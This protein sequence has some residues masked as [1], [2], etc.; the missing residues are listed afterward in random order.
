MFEKYHEDIEDR[1]TSVANAV[2]DICQK[3][4]KYGFTVGYHL[5]DHHIPKANNGAWDIKGNEFDD[6]DNRW[7]AYYSEDY[8]N[9]YKKKSGKYLYV[10]RAEISP[11]SSHKRD[12]SNKWGR[13][14][15]LSIIDECDMREIEQGIN[16]AIKN[17]DAAP[18]RE[19]A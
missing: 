5:S 3:N 8:L 12:L 6:R 4:K 15:L 9:R 13:A 16:E 19:A 17:E 7:M 18:Q 10:V 11:D 2:R 1:R 14:S